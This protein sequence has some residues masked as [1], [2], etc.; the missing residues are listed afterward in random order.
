MKLRN[1]SQVKNSTK[2]IIMAGGEGTRLWPKSH[3]L[4]PKQFN[5]FGDKKTLV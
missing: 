4:R 2:V 3:A 1:F 5:H